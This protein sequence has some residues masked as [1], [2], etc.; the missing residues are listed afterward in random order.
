MYSQYM[1]NMTNINP[2]YAGN[3]GVPSLSIIWREQWVG[4]QGS[5]S[6][7]SFTYDLPSENKKM[8]LVS[9]FMMINMLIISKE[10]D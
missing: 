10:Q 4:L 5:P 8:V 2:A 1:Y 9:S 3:R 7:K 6:T